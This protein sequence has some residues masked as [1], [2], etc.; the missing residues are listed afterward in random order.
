MN[1]ARFWT[2]NVML[3]CLAIT[4]VLALSPDQQE[5]FGTVEGTVTYRGHPV[6]GGT[7]FF[8]SPD[9]QR[10]DDRH[11]FIDDNGHYQTDSS[12]QRDREAPTRFR[13]FVVLKEK[14]DPSDTP[15]ARADADGREGEATRIASG[16]GGDVPPAGAIKPPSMD[17]PPLD[18]P[19]RQI[20]RWPQKRFSNLATSG[21]EAV[22]G[23][24]PA[25][26]DV[27]LKD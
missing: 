4:V 11:A 5:E 12:W 15:S 6:K 21:L 13:I 19:G 10:S 27:Q 1:T 20:A 22:L 18:A 17:C 24:G 9:R 14:L 2:G 16:P 8:V 23:A 25:R 26:V 3:S 7:I